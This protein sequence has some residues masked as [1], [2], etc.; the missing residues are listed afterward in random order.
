MVRIA[1]CQ[2]NLTVGDIDGNVQR[3]R[4]GIEHA[5]DH[6]AELIVFPELCVTGYPPEDLLLRS[7]FCEQA[8][9]AVQQL[10]TNVQTAVVVIGY[11]HLSGSLFNSAAVLADGQVQA[12]Y[13]K[14][15]LPNYS[16]FDEKRYF[17]S[18][19]K[20]MVVN[21]NGVAVGVTICEDLWH[22]DGPGKEAI[23]DGT[24]QLI[25]NLSASPYHKGKGIEREELFRTR[26]QDYNCFIAFCNAVGGQ[27]ELV[28]DGH[29][30]IISPTGDVLA[31]GRQ[32]EEDLVITDIEV[33]RNLTTPPIA[34]DQVTH[35]TLSTLNKAK[36][37]F[38][39]PQRPPLLAEEAEVYRALVLGTADYFSKNG[40]QKAVLG[41][42][43]GIDSAVSLVIAADALGPE[44]I[45][46]V[47]M[48]SRYTSD[49]NRNDASELA[50]QLGVNLLEL[51]IHKLVTSY[52]ETLTPLF[53]DTASNVAEENLQARIRGNLVMALSNK[54]SWLVLTTGNK[55]EMSVGYATLYGDMAGGFSVLKDV[56]KTWVYRIAEWYNRNHEI[57]PR[58]IIEK[59][60]TAELR[61]NQLDTDSLPP[62]PELDTI[63]KAYVEDNLTLAEIKSLGFEEEL[64]RRIVDMVDSAE[65]KRRQAPPGIRI[66]KRAFGKDRRLPI[67]NKFSTE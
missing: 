51:P 45:T 16:V 62:Y 44:A 31:R 1:L 8:E 11:P 6:G 43:G 58:R 56:L 53:H 33:D 25:V 19:D 66:T 55:S 65:Y 57:I 48:P 3:I 60:P 34:T 2:A 20:G 40:F 28:F 35:V 7:R 12:I 39:T 27:D 36:P 32:F 47:S 37:A 54:F 26:C 10:A 52:D 61:E 49:A 42:S 4:A 23:V 5:C 18:G 14:C 59:A 22:L 67:T 63:L 24:T 13:R 17:A 15:L 46:A 21:I 9:A 30:L 41:L 50:K 64:V 38:E 29:S